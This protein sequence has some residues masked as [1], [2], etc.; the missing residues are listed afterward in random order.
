M[1]KID[2]CIVKLLKI[3]LLSF[4]FFVNF[5]FISYSIEWKKFGDLL[6][7]RSQHQIQQINDSLILVMG[8]IPDDLYT[9]PAKQT[10]ELINLK[11]KSIS[12]TS[13]MSIG[14][15]YFVS[16]LTKDSNVVVMGGFS[17]NEIVELF[18]RKTFSW[19][20][21]GKLLEWRYQHT[22]SFIND[23]EIVVIGGVT[24]ST[25]GSSKCEIFN[26]NTGNS[27]YISDIGLGGNGITSFYSKTS[28]SIYAL[29]GRNGGSNSLRSS[30][31]F[32]YTKNTNSWK[33]NDYL[34]NPTYRV[35]NIELTDSSNIITGGSLSE[36]PMRNSKDI[37]LE[38][39]GFVSF[40]GTL[41]SER[42]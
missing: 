15:A 37:F 39:N 17:G 23:S 22:A 36:S 11:S 28:N 12:Y 30:N 40:K 29:G 24:N 6:E 33:I 32:N 8:G 7:A 25:P 31:I 26:I 16:L 18:D 10:C 42:L 19:R 20:T 9:S 35:N 1:K 38:K 4:L 3:L 34:L 5:S 27:K 13:S 2:V 21:I 41:I 14:R